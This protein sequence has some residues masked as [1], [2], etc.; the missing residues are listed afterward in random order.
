M[1]LSSTNPPLTFTLSPDQ[2]AALNAIHKFLCSPVETAFVLQGYSGCGK[3]TLIKTL[4]DNLPN[5][6]K[7]ARLIQPTIRDYITQLTATTNKAAENLAQITGMECTTIHSFLGLRVQTDY[8]TNVTTLIPKNAEVKRGYLVI[9]DEAS[10]IDSAMLQHI[11][12]KLQDC[13]ILFVGDPAQLIQVKATGAPVFDLKFSGAALTQVVR[14]A[15][16]NPIID[17]STQFRHTV[18]GSPWPQ[19]TPDGQTIQYLD[20]D[21]FND[22]I[23]TEFSRPDWHYTDSKVLAWTNK[24][25][26]DFNNYIRANTNGD[27][28]FEVGDYAVCNSFLAVGSKS[29]KT[30]QL[31]MITGISHGEERHGVA[32]SLFTLDGYI[33]AFMPTSLKE[34]N[35]R[36]RQARANNELRIVADIDQS[37][38]DLR[39]ASAQTIN[40]S[41]GST[42]GSVFIDLDDV[43]RCNS[44]DA[45]ARMLYVAVSRAK[46]HVFLTGDLVS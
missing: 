44:G 33:T 23:L 10:F 45:I 42:Y 39:A 5:F 29:I 25:A 3:S 13:K 11:F 15:E 14:Q 8:K 34:R 20:R 35:D 46:N 38:A 6:M 28:S 40:K 36:V 12:A 31:V 43:S 37:W 16:G 24:C 1:S 21:D 27:P 9:I 18:N 26:I 41:Q 32:G 7:A 4:L 22:K 30:D 2:E 19:L 17:L